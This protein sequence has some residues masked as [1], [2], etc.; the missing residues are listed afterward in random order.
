MA[1]INYDFVDIRKLRFAIASQEEVVKQATE[2]L[3]RLRGVQKLIG[4]RRVAKQP[5]AK[6]ATTPTVKKRD[7]KPK[8]PVSES[9]MAAVIAVLKAAKGPI[10][11]TELR[12]R[13]KARGCDI[14]DHTLSVYL[15]HNKCGGFKNVSLGVWQWELKKVT[16]AAPAA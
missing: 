1:R 11:I 16:S 3:N 14:D 2:Q 6:A 12:A 8:A 13:L 7:T 4:R 15:S 10:K 9:K 5:A